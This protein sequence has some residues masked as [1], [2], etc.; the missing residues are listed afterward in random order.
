MRQGAQGTRQ[1]AT[2]GGH[3]ARADGIRPS[4]AE[5]EALDLVLMGIVVVSMPALV[6]IGAL[7]WLIADQFLRRIGA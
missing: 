6:M 7:V 1:Q 3:E 5:R 2:P 4:R